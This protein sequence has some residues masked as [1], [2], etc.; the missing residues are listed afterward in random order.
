[1]H[2]PYKGGAPAL[3]ALVSGET[4][5]SY[6]NSLIILPQIKAGKVKALAVTTAKRSAL[7]PE[8]PTIGETLRVTARAAGMAW[9]LRPQHPRTHSQS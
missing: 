8:L 9:S 4:D 6:E 1:V 7:L 3:A 2:V 5:M